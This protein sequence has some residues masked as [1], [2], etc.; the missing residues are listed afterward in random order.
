MEDIFEANGLYNV[1]KLIQ[2]SFFDK[3][4]YSAINK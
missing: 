3:L 4:F 2:Q 1:L